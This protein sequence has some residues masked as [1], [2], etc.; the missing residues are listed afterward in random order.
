MS[1]VTL[2][3]SSAERIAVEWQKNKQGDDSVTDTADEDG[4]K[5][6]ANPSNGAKTDQK[7]K[8]KK[9]KSKRFVFEAWLSDEVT[10]RSEHK[11]SLDAA[12]AAWDFCVNYQLQM[13][14][15]DWYSKTRYGQQECLNVM[16]PA[17]DWEPETAFIDY[18]K[19]HAQKK[20]VRVTNGEQFIAITR[21]E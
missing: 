13:P 7:K 11:M 5:Q 17:G 15:A 2:I 6:K 8:Y 1:N 16:V 18:M 3:T 19:K 12:N 21:Q 9:K 20:G 14:S 10:E 4:K